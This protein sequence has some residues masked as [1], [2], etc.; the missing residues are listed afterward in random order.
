MIRE[1]HRERYLPAFVVTVPELT[2]LVDRL[3]ASFEKPGDVSCYIDIELPRQTL[4]FTSL[5]ELSS[6]AELPSELTEFK[7]TLIQGERSISIKPHLLDDSNRIVSC[8]G[9]DEAWCAGVI[10]I[11]LLFFSTRKLWY[12]FFTTAPLF[13]ILILAAVS[14]WV[15]IVFDQS[16]S[17][18]SAWLKPY[19]QSL[20]SWLGIVLAFGAV[21]LFR[22]K[23]LPSSIIL[24]KPRETFQQNRIGEMSLVIAVIALIVSIITPFLAR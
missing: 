3:A 2:I 23:L 5:T 12:S 4:K 22:K 20:L 24:L 18:F 16:N 6:C 19:K 9:D 15:V 10:E 11:T 13:R 8:R 21:V 14:I 7:L 17:T 1:I